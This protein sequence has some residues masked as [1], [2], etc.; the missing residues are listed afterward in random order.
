LHSWVRTEGRNMLL[1]DVAIR[2]FIVKAPTVES[3]EAGLELLRRNH[4]LGNCNV[5][6]IRQNAYGEPGFHAFFE[7]YEEQQ[8]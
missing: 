3:V 4:R 7:V 2:K 8:Q 6:R 5:S 1:T